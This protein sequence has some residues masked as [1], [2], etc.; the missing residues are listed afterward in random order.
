MSVVGYSVTG[1]LAE[2]VELTFFSTMY[3]QIIWRW[4]FLL[5]GKAEGTRNFTAGSLRKQY[6]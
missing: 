1:K 5:N 2:A 3:A 6:C 4:L